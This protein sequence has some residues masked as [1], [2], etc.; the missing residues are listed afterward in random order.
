MPN[1]KHVTSAEVRVRLKDGKI[2]QT[3]VDAPKGHPLDNPLSKSE[4]EQKFIDN[5]AFS[6][7][8]PARKAKTALDM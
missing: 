3:H 1:E 5:V 7:T 2:F 8:I 4:I 6:R